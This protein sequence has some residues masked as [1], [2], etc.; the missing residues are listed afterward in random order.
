MC[1]AP[2]VHG[3]Q[4]LS[5]RADRHRDAGRP[6]DREAKDSRRDLRTACSA[7]RASSGSGE[8][9]DGILELDARRRRRARRCSSAMPLGDTRL[10]IDVGANRPDLL[11]HLGVAREIAAVTRQPLDAARRSASTTPTIPRAEARPP[12]GQRRRHRRCI[13]ED[14]TLVRAVHGRRHS[15]RDGRS[16]PA[17]GSCD[18]LEPVGSR[19]INNVVDATQLRAARARPADARVRSRQARL[20]RSC[21]DRRR[22]RAKPGE[23]LATLDGVERALTRRDDRHRRRRARPQAIAGVMGGQDSEVD[24]RRRPTSSSR[25][26]TSIRGAFATHAPRARPVDRRELS[27]RARRGRRR[28]RRGRSSASRGSS[29]RSPAAASTARRWISTPATRRRSRSSLRTH[30]ASQRV[31]GVPLRAERRRRRCFAASAATPT[32]RIGRCGALSCRRPGAA[33]S[34]REV[35]LIEEVARLHGYEQLPDEIRPFRP[36]TSADAPLWITTRACATRSSAPGML[37]VRPMPF[38]AGGDGHVRAAQSARRERGVSAPHVLETLARRAEYNLVAHAGQRPAVRDRLRVRARRRRF[39]TRRCASRALVMGDRDPAHF[40]GPASVG[41]RRVGCEGT[42]RAHRAHARSPAATS[43]SSRPSD[44]VGRAL[45]RRGRRR[46]ARRGAAR[47]ARRAGVG[48]PAFGVELVLGVIER[49][50]RAAGRARARRRAGAA[51]AHDSAIPRAAVD[52]G[53]GVRPRSLRPA[54]RPRGAGGADD[55]RRGGRAARAPRAVRP[56]RGAASTGPSVVA[57]RL[58]L[59]HPERTLRDKEIEGRR[60]KI[61]AALQQELN[62]RQ[63]TS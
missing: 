2:N 16:E 41:I 61:L 18:R 24:R 47:P 3:G 49:R 19:S 23:K 15:R 14:A 39:P 50:R 29:S 52:S 28:S 13:V 40:T 57:W 59:R 7:R 38:V 17:S 51:G 1:G 31:L 44:G 46:G 42:R 34:S 21:R 10:V 33:T 30:R 48:E 5:V 22:A 43:R 63:R 35:D 9:H 36:G 58:T 32:S 37:E 54:R 26:R 55:P 12:R 56:V 27:L 8:E 11:S 20:E 45:A 62:V 6:Q 25:S 60:N 53:R 4:A